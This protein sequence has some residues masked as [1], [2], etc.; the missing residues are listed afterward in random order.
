[1]GGRE[2]LVLAALQ[3]EDPIEIYPVIHPIPPLSGG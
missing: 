2:S 1:M 3:C